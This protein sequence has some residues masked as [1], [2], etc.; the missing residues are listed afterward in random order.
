MFSSIHFNIIKMHGTT[1][2]TVFCLYAIHC[3]D[4]HRPPFALVEISLFFFYVTTIGIAQIIYRRTEGPFVNKHLESKQSSRDLRHYS[5]IC[6]KGLKN[7]T[8][9][10]NFRNKIRTVQH[11]NESV[12]P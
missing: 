5:I 10:L 7:T 1:M 3:V 9:N 11:R 4:V 2:K 8:K 12:K 6:H